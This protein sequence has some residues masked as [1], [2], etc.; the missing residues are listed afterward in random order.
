MNTEKLVLKG[1]ISELQPE[2]MVKYEETLKLLKE[3][4]SVDSVGSILAVTMFGIEMSES[5]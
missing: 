3:T 2:E 1:L 5:V 4:V